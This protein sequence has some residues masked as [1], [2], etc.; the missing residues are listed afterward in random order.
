MPRLTIRDI[1]SHGDILILEPV[2]SQGLKFEASS[3]PTIGSVVVVVIAGKCHY[4]DRDGNVL[5]TTDRKE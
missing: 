4:V 5:Y 1:V 2:G 3:D